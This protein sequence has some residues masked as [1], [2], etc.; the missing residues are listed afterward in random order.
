MRLTTLVSL[1]WPEPPSPAAATTNGCPAEGV[2]PAVGV[3]A[4]LLTGVVEIPLLN[5]TVCAAWL[6]LN[7]SL[8]IA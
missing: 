7:P 1:D 3:N 6:L 8:M 5:V 2:V 4:E